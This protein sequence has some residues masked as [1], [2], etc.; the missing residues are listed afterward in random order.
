VHPNWTRRGLGALVLSA[1]EDAA[2]GM[3]F[4]RAEMGATVGFVSW[5][6]VV[7]F[8]WTYALRLLVLRR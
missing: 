6:E 4:V 7:V 2:R 8:R 1:C 3:G 5:T